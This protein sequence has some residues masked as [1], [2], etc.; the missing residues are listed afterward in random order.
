[1]AINKPIIKLGE[2]SIIP[3]DSIQSVESVMSNPEIAARM[4][5]ELILERFKKVSSDL[6]ALAPKAKDFLYFSAIMMHA[7]EAALLDDKGKTRKHADGKD[8]TVSWEKKGDSWKWVCSD[9]GLKAYKNSNNDIFPEEELIR[10]HKKWVGRPLCLDHKSDSVDMIR[11]VIVDTYYDY[12]NKRVIALCALDKVNYPDL[13]RK[14]SSGYAASVSMGTA[15]GRAICTDCGRVA[16]T[17]KDYCDCMRSRRCYGEINVDLNPIELSIVV[18]GADPKAKIRHIVAAAQ[19]IATYI[20]DKEKL[21]NK[22]SSHTGVDLSEISSLKEDLTRVLDRVAELERAFE[23]AKK[24]EQTEENLPEN[25][26]NEQNSEENLI[27]MANNDITNEE[28]KKLAGVLDDIKKNLGTLN[29]NV[30]RLLNNNEDIEMST[31]QAYFQGGG[32]ANEPAPG[33]VKYPKEDYQSLRDGQDKQMVG[34]TPFPEV[35]KVDDLYPGDKEV[36]QQILRAEEKEQRQ[37]RRQSALSK[38]KAALENK[39]AYFQGGGGLN[40]PSPGKPKYQ[41]EDYES[42]RDDE[43]KQMVGKKPFPDV[44]KIDGLYPGDKET[45]EKLLRAKLTAQFVKAAN[46]DDTDNKAD[47]CWQVFADNRLVLQGTVKDITRG[48][49]DG[50]YN[51]VATEAFGKLILK[52]IRSDNGFEK[53]QGLLKGAQMAPADP[54]MAATPPMAPPAEPLAAPDAEMPAPDATDLGGTGDPK[55]ELFSLLDELQNLGADIREG[56]ESLAGDS[57]DELD[58]FEEMAGGEGAEGGEL[59]EAA[60]AVASMISMQKKLGGSLLEGMQK[61]SSE[62]EEYLGEMKMA[63]FSYE[64]EKVAGVGREAL[65]ALTASLVGDVKECIA[66]SY[67]LLGAFVKYAYGTQNVVKQAR[68]YMAMKKTAED[69]PKIPSLEDAPKVPERKLP[70]HKG[71]TWDGG[72]K[73]APKEAP[74]DSHK[75]DDCMADTVKM[76]E[77][78]VKPVETD[79]T[80]GFGKELLTP[81]AEPLDTSAWK[82][83]PPVWNPASG[84]SEQDWNRRMNAPEALFDAN[85]TNDLTI[86]DGT[87]GKSMKI[88]PSTGQ[89]LSATK[90]DMTTKEGRA[91]FRR[92]MTVLAQTGLKCNPVLDEAHP[93]GGFT[94]Q[95]DTKVSDDLAKVETLEEQHQAML[96]VAN[97]PPKV[98]KAAADIQKHVI[99]GNINPEKDFPNLV[100]VGLDPAAVA[101]WKQFYGQGDATSKEFATELTK[102]VSEKKAQE[103][104]E[105]FKVKIARA[106][107]MAYDM[108]D[109]S[110]LARNR[111]AISAQVKEIMSFNDAGFESLARWVGNQP[112]VKTASSLPL[113]GMGQG[114]LSDSVLMASGSD[115]DLASELTSLWAGGRRGR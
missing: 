82:K 9:R 14:V 2:L 57:G 91:E 76:P 66:T 36:K 44:G 58:S 17:E 27:D 33:Q 48:D 38:A 42:I 75:A 7:A 89:K 73:E 55:E 103:E 70:V 81:P 25:E 19:S 74:K 51:K 23:D 87:T 20:D 49:V 50:Q 97:A 88:N 31:K 96:D 108:V 1:M 112:V 34:E 106:Y 68:T 100:A 67:D 80:G 79:I 47:S 102:Q 86:T 37:L 3:T 54:S 24:C 5:D 18:N 29:S 110:M 83:A 32:G 30:N 56:V 90:F 104:M 64:N 22:I 69:A 95:L 113:V 72:P 93:Q 11:G 105:T 26:K 99:A 39:N 52:T 85:N 65:D 109:R 62:I 77:E 8:I 78:P 84:E 45:K 92:H 71:P 40:E 28:I 21:V 98:K 60:Q 15:V 59:P 101:Y 111:D 94:T 46:L 4:S 53:A 10:A 12:P 43:D 114:A 16:R 41:K 13:A 6:K 115:T 61:T 107:E 35:G 63:K